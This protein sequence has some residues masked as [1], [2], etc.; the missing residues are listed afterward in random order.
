MV[1]LAIYFIHNTFLYGFTYHRTENRLYSIVLL[2]LKI[3]ILLN[4]QPYEINSVKDSIFRGNTIN[5]YYVS[6]F[7][8]GLLK[9]INS[10]LKKI[11]P[12][13]IYHKKR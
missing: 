7:N 3:I 11:I 10:K 2:I 13:N 6:T 1:I 4:W 12:C 5:Y 8:C 9:K